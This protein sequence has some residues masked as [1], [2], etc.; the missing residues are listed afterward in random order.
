MI[1]HKYKA[2]YHS[3]TVLINPDLA[4]NKFYTDIFSSTVIISNIATLQLLSP[5][6]KKKKK[7]P[8]PLFFLSFILLPSRTSPRIFTALSTRS[9]RFY[10]MNISSPRR[11]SSANFAKRLT[12]LNNAHW[13]APLHFVDEDATFSPCVILFPRSSIEQF[14]IGRLQVVDRVILRVPARREFYL[15]VARNVSFF[16]LLVLCLSF[17]IL[18]KMEETLSSFAIRKTIGKPSLG[19]FFGFKFVLTGC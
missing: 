10:P 4:V 19:N 17:E 5:R 16:L 2:S 1:K 15:T 11:E 13:D 18:S 14:E 9:N 6:K 7:N 12:L 8:F 3:Y